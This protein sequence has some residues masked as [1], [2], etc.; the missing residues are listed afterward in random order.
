MRLVQGT[1]GALRRDIDCGPRALDSFVE[2][3]TI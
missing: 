2:E 1:L 3:L